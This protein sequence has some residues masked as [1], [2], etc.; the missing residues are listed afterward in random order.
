MSHRRQRISLLVITAIKQF[1]LFIFSH[2]VAL[3][4]SLSLSVFHALCFFCISRNIPGATL[5]HAYD[6]VTV[7]IQPGTALHR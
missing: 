6:F 3:T 5:V 2:L 4:L 1:S 7:F